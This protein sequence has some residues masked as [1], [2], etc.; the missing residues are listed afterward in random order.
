MTT[1]IEQLRD[2]QTK[3][4]ED[5]EQKIKEIPARDLEMIRLR[6]VEGLTLQTIATRYG[7]TRQRVFQVVNRP[8]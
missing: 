2:L 6:F 8:L 1:T 4:R 7:L 5:K 3:A